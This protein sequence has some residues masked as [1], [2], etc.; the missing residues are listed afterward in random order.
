MTSTEDKDC[1]TGEAEEEL[2]LDLKG[3][4]WLRR[5]DH[6]GK[7]DKSQ[8]QGEIQTEPCDMAHT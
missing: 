2:L 7:M 1:S 5:R 8:N 4:R 6:Y 3:Q